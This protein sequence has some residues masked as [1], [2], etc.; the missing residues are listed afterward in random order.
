ML[1]LQLAYMLSRDD[2]YTKHSYM[3]VCSVVGSGHGAGSRSGSL[4]TATPDSVVDVEA[5]AQE[6][7]AELYDVVWRKCRIAAEIEIFDADAIAGA[8]FGVAVRRTKTHR[9]RI[10]ATQQPKL[11]SYLGVVG[12]TQVVGT[13][14]AYHVLN[15]VMSQQS[16][17]TAISLLAMPPLPSYAETAASADVAPDKIEAL[18]VLTQDCGPVVLVKEP[19]LHP[20]QDRR[21]VCATAV[22][23]GQSRQSACPCEP[24]YDPALQAV[25]FQLPVMLVAEPAEQSLQ[26]VRP[27]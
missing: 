17:N 21:P 9:H 20:S 8:N 15:T 1:Q 25:Q 27:F 2:F 14:R 24:W 22:P 18:N 26:D 6:R 12:G 5:T 13:Q 11:S 3:R 19:G 10:S 23:A 16:Y 7:C 4:W